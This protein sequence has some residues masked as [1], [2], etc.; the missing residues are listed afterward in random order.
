MLWTLLSA[1][2]SVSFLAGAIVWARAHGESTFT[3]YG[4]AACVGLTCGACNIWL[5]SRLASVVT[6]RIATYPPRI[7]ERYLMPLYVLAGF[8]SVVA[9]ALGY[10]FA[11]GI[12]KLFLI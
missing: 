8:W 11:T 5:W 7:Q 6:E 1:I 4:L 12:A 10:W 3:A 2:N 9:A